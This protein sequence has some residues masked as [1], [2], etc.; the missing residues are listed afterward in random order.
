MLEGSWT[1]ITS[2]NRRLFVF[3]LASISLA[4]LAHGACIRGEYDNSVASFK[5]GP[6]RYEFRHKFDTA[7]G[8]FTIS[9]GF[10]TL[11][12]EG[13]EQSAQFYINPGPEA[14]NLPVAG[15]SITGETRAELAVLGWSG[16]AHCCFSLYIY[17]LGNHPYL[18]QKIDQGHSE[19]VR[20][21]YFNRDPVPGIIVNDWTFA[22]WKISFAQSPAPEVILRYNGRHWAFAPNLMFKPLPSTRT[23]KKMR[24]SITAAFALARASASDGDYSD[25]GAPVV[26]WTYL[27]DLI[28]S[29]HADAAWSLLNNTW[30]PD[31]PNRLRF[32]EQFHQRLVHSS[33]FVDLQ[34]M[35]PKAP[36]L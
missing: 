32:A 35:N 14:C 21:A 30:P 16:G 1:F 24:K 15:K 29:G 13:E 22:Y 23:L 26:L 6:F 7:Q 9:K 4:P 34:K 31:N 8:Y 11:F 27:I 36:F 18:I 3:V 10:D 20:F 2:P 12:T 17:A 33:Y 5:I 25:T 28:Y 19:V